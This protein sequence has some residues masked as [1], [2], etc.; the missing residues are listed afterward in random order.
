MKT[1][2]YVEINCKKCKADVLKAVAKLSDVD[3]IEVD[4]EKNTVTVT[5]KVDPMDVMTNLRKVKKMAQ[6][7]T[8][9]SEKEEAKKDEKKEGGGPLPDCCRAC[10]YIYVDFLPYSRPIECAIL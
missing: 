3:K 4:E 9:G 10:D 8:V 5:G 2:V 1:V 7:L 6:M